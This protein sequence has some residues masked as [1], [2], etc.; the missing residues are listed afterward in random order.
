ML[1]DLLKKSPKFSKIIFG[2][3]KVYFKPIF[4]SRLEMDFLVITLVYQLIVKKH[5]K[6]KAMK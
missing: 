6:P 4:T 2:T 5:E 3:A 1:E